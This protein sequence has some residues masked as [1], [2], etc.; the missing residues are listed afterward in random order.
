MAGLL[1]P[2]LA[3]AAGM[4]S[5]SSP[6]CLPLLPTY[7]SYMAGVPVGKD[8][9]TARRT[10]VRAAVAFVAGFTTVFTVLGALAGALGSTLVRQLPLMVRLSGILII[11]MGF[12]M[13]G[14]VRIPYLAR[15]R[16]VV[17]LHRIGH[18]PGSA[19]LLGAAFAAGWSP[20]LGPVLATI[21]ATAATTR[22]IGW[23]MALL[24]LYSIGLGLPFIALALG[25]NRAQRSVAWLRRHTLAVERI[26]ALLLVT[27]GVLFVTGA[28]RTLL[29]PL[30]H[31]LARLGWPPI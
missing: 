23:G 31:S 10:T 7:I 26:S 30:Q 28:W 13:L 2:F 15:E 27:I 25:L 6:C 1:L 12:A 20:C 29:L 4:L 11:V 17:H 16:R 3:V 14:V 21:L 5:F 18:G 9:S 24:A 8:P 22:T 19:G